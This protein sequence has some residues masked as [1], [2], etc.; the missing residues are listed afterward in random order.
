MMILVADGVGEGILGMAT[1]FCCSDQAK[2]EPLVGISTL[3]Q[4]DSPEL[5]IV[6]VKIFTNLPYV[7]WGSF[8]FPYLDITTLSV[9]T[10]TTQFPLTQLCL[11]RLLQYSSTQV[12]LRWEKEGYRLKVIP[13]LKEALWENSDEDHC[14]SPFIPLSVPIASFHSHRDAGSQTKEAL[15]FN[16]PLRQFQAVTQART[17]LEWELARNQEDQLAKMAEQ[18]NTTFKE[19]LSQISQAHLVR[20]LPWFLSATTSP[21]AGPVCSVIEALTTVMQPKADAS[22]YNTTWEFK[23]STAPASMSS[24]ACQANTPPPPD[25]PM[26]DILVAC[27]PIGSPL[28]K[29]A[30]SPEH[31]KQNCSPDSTLDDQGGKRDHPETTEVDASG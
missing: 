30:I 7:P 14:L 10:S 17:Q 5:G 18:V 22:V 6:V 12:I 25:L 3:F 13:F 19:V 1:I 8:G 23:G 16:V 24:P 15:S 9:G 20:L 31:K 28:F 29:L 4:W 26:L 21:G 2:V 11:C 27:T